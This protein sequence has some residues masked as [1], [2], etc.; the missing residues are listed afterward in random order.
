MDEGV[1]YIAVILVCG[2]FADNMLVKDKLKKLKE[3]IE[4]LQARLD[5]K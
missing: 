5:K 1:G 4:E 3:R 2:L